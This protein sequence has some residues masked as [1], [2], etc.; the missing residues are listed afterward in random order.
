MAYSI[1]TNSSPRWNQFGV[2]DL[3]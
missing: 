2:L 1:D 3:G